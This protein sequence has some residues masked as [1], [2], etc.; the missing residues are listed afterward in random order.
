[1]AE[2][3]G[4]CGCGAVQFEIDEPLVGAAYCHCTRCQ[5]RTGSAASASALMKPGS[6]RITQGEDKLKTW[7]PEGG[8]DKTFCGECGSA[9]FG[10]PPGEGHAIV[11]MGV[12]DG[13]PGVRMMARQM[14]AYAA[15]WEP[16]PDDGLPRFDES[17]P[18]D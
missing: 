6:L 12:I 8:W 17:L 13:D 11:R 10:G 4:S 3:T 14:V 2:L 1:M 15:P 9:M 16:I 18:R 7:S 5:R